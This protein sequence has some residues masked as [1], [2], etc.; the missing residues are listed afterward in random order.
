MLFCCGLTISAV[1]THSAHPAEPKSGESGQKHLSWHSPDASGNRQ[2]SQ[3]LV[4]DEELREA[5]DDVN[6][7]LGER[8]IPAFPRGF[9]WFQLVPPGGTGRDVVKTYGRVQ[10][11][12]PVRHDLV[13]E[14]AYTRAAIEELY[15]LPVTP[16]PPIPAE[17][18]ETLPDDQQSDVRQRAEQARAAGLMAGAPGAVPILRCRTLRRSLP[19]YAT[20][21]FRAEDLDG[22]AVL[23]NGTTELHISRGNAGAPGGCLIR[24]PDAT[25][26]WQQLQG[27]EMLGPL[28]NDNPGITTFTLLD[29]DNNR[30]IF[31]SRR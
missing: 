20:L 14:T 6:G 24:V 28:E 25:A 10:G 22:Y 15:G 27:L 3:R 9:R 5:H 16:P 31:L 29:P 13:L 21:G 19:F 4:T 11:E 8:E 26:L 2:V 18:W 23:R 17:A 7:L 1:I 12:L 30:L